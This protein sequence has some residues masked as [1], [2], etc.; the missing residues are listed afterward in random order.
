MVKPGGSA[1]IQQWVPRKKL[2]NYLLF[3]LKESTVLCKLQKKKEAILGALHTHRLG[4]T[5]SL[6]SKK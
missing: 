1:E 2:T 3:N 6:T 5:H 4:R